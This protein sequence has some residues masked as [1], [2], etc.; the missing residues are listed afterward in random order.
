MQG[1]TQCARRT[2]QLFRTLRTKLGR[3]NRPQTGDPITQLILGVFTRDAQEPKAREALESLKARVVD[4]NELRV[5]PPLE[6]SEYIGEYPDVR[7]KCQDVSR[8]LNRIFAIEHSVSL[9]R[10][11]AASKTEVNNYLNGIPGLEAYS[12]ARIKLLGLNQHAVPLD[13]AMWAYARQQEIVDESCSLDE[14]QAFL[15]RQVE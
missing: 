12:R 7:T 5:I 4:Y 6:M 14:A 1:A 2:R 9:E 11:G 10:I 15:E 8:A 3:V 13:E